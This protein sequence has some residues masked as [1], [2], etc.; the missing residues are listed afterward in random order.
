MA[1]HAGTAHVNGG[2]GAAQHR[3]SLSRPTQ[4]D[5]MCVL[6]WLR[7]C[8][9]KMPVYEY[10]S[11]KIGQRLLFCDLLCATVFSSLKEYVQGGAQ[12][13][14][15]SAK[16]SCNHAVPEIYMGVMPAG[17][18]LCTTHDLQGVRRQAREEVVGMRG[19]GRGLTASSVRTAAWED[20]QM[21]RG[22]KASLSCQPPRRDEKSHEIY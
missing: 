16:K 8:T 4:L 22:E 15:Y 14:L 12:S 13:S 5:A 9:R 19:A 17:G 6:G 20:P 11:Q 18:D 21:A 7:I 10:R 1:D 3:H 2:R